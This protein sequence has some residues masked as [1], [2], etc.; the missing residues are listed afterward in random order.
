MRTAQDRLDQSHNSGKPKTHAK[1]R[2]TGGNRRNGKMK[3]RGAVR[4]KKQWKA[5]KCQQEKTYKECHLK[6]F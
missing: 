4:V 2:G 5:I 1:S 3:Q 6:G